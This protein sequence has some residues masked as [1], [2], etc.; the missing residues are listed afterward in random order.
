M[1]EQ[2]TRRPHLLPATGS[3]KWGLGLLLA[4]VVLFL[5]KAVVPFPLPSMLI[6]AIGLVGLFLALVALF[7]R[8]WSIAMIAAAVLIGGFIL[9]WVVG[10]LLFPH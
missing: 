5:L 8:D 7:K 10:E 6:F 4:F 2:S 9:F 3:G 1:T